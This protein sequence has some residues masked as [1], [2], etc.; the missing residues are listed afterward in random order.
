MIMSRLHLP[1]AWPHLLLH[2][3]LFPLFETGCASCGGPS[4]LAICDGCQA[5]LEPLPAHRCSRC[6]GRLS[7]GSCRLCRHT[8]PF[9]TIVALGRYA[10]VL[11][12]VVR[13]L[14]YH[15]RP[16]LGIWAGSQL[17]RQLGPSEKGVIVPMPV[18]PRRRRERGYNQTEPV[19]WQLAKDLDL[20]YEPRL[21]V[22]CQHAAP[23]Y[24]RDRQARWREAL[25]AFRA[26]EERLAGRSVWL[27]EDVVTSGATIWGAASCL[28]AAGA[29]GVR[30]ATI[31]R[32][33]GP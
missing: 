17:A 12:S 18:H 22:R 21:L 4:R 13:D 23:S 3:L 25:Q 27:I 30:V 19:A 1:P 24:Q 29:T 32:T 16:D 5:R 2:R 26:D 9:E 28:K 15:G 20:P 11:R 8:P 33:L 7:G 14:K 31:A 6:Q 10:G